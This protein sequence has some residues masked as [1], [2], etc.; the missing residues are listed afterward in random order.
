M[1]WTELIFGTV[2]TL[3]LSYTVL[4]ENS[5]NSKN[6]GI[7]LCNLDPISEISQFS[8][9]FMQENWLIFEVGSRLQR[10]IPV[11]FELP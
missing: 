6:A 7:S 3:G 10:E 4:N 8:C 9:I 11:F 5:S 2:G 1:E